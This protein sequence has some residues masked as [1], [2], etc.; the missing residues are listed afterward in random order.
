LNPDT[1]PRKPLTIMER[2]SLFV[3]L[4]GLLVPLAGVAGYRALERGQMAPMAASVTKAAAVSMETVKPAYTEFS[5][6]FRRN[7]T[8]TTA[9][10]RHGLSGQEAADLVQAARP[11]WP[12]VKVKAGETFQ[13]NLY[14][15]G[16]FHE[17]RYRL[18]R[19]RY[20]TIYRHGGKFV[21]EVKKFD[22]DVRTIAV[23]GVIRN[24]LFVAIS[25][26]GEQEALADALANIFAWDVDF[27]TDI[28]TGD[29][30]QILLEKQFLNGKLDRYGDILAAEITV[31]KKRFS[32]FRFQNEYY[33]NNGRSLKKALLKSPLNFAARISSRFSG[34]RL[35]PILRI[36]RP[37]YGVD[38][39]VP[40]GTPVVAVAAGK[41]TFA[42]VDGGFGKSVRLRHDFGGLETVYSHLSVI[43][44]RAGQQVA[45]GAWIGNVGATGLATGPHLDFRVFEHGRPKNPTSKIVP[46]APPVSAKLLPQFK[47]QRDDLRAHLERMLQSRHDL[48]APVPA[49]AA[50]EA[51]FRHF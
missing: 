20:I 49:Q 24:S 10:K 13:G 8:I 4:L 14:P 28:Q 27:N 42:G 9:L 46:D 40:S 48:A 33:D 23:D 22:F 47:A 11:I 30:F 25:D 37:H 32:A 18:D 6:T 29:T 16:A 44:V 3:A 45:Q 26:T 19:E 36:A 43:G 31:G 17:F 41:V 5:D 34:S 39:A 50:G 1:A 21:P 38:Y 15:D 35:H 2:R 51:G 12:R 7:D